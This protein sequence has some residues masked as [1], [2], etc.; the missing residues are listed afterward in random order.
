[1]TRPGHEHVRDV[2]LLQAW[3]LERGLGVLADSV[4][5]GER[6]AVGLHGDAGS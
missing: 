1:M 5:P 3:F 6:A 2:A 4:A